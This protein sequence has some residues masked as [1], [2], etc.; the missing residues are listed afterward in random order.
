MATSF[1]PAELMVDAYA[2]A[3][4]TTVVVAVPNISLSTPAGSPPIITNGGRKEIQAV[5]G[6]P[7]TVDINASDPN[8]YNGFVFTGVTQNNKF[9]YS[10]NT[11]LVAQNGQMHLDNI[12]TPLL[13]SGSTLTNQYKTGGHFTH[14]IFTWTPTAADNNTSVTVS[15]IAG[16]YYYPATPVSRTMNFTIN[17]VD[18]TTPS[19]AMN[20]EQTLVMGFEAKIPVTVIPDT[21]NDS[22]LISASNLPNGAVLGPAAKNAGGQWVAVLTWTPSA[23]QIGSSTI[24]FEAQDAQES[25]VVSSQVVFIVQN[26]A[27]PAFSSSMPAMMEAAQNVAL[28]YEIIVIPDAQTSDVLLTATGL[29]PGAV[30]SKPV[31]KNGQLVASMTWQPDA[32]QIGSNFSVT[33]T[34]EDNVAGAVPVMFTTTFTAVPHYSVINRSLFRR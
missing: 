23:A 6:Q 1:E 34:A 28:T 9:Y 13:P 27:S 4:S 32:S 21:D 22:V 10:A 19:F 33:F 20:A 16:N 7:L 12:K 3:S 2:G 25:T 15:V 14:S 31:L 8:G 5:V 29:P 30:L 18:A 26:G 17:T 11:Y 24:T